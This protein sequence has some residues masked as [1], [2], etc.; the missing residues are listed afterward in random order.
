MIDDR[1]IGITGAVKKTGGSISRQAIYQ[2]IHSGHLPTV[3]INGKIK[4]DTN[5]MIVA[6]Y[7]N[8][9]MSRNG[10]SGKQFKG[11][12]STVR[13]TAA[14]KK[15]VKA[16]LVKKKQEPDEEDEGDNTP[17]L[18]HK[19]QLLK[20]DLQN[21]QLRIKNAEARKDLIPTSFVTIIFSKIYSILNNE[22]LQVGPALSSRV[23]EMVFKTN[24]EIKLSA[25]QEV[26]D[27][28]VRGSLIHIKKTIEIMLK[29]IGE[30]LG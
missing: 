13:E 15:K 9:A 4:L 25:A 7:L 29:E 14:P 6:D 21:E 17:Q 3:K 1:Y 28:G 8:Q 27:D 2:A 16:P 18:K 20:L 22:Y 30:K 10:Y 24:D 26:I 19:A 23:C 5:D 12:P 11:D